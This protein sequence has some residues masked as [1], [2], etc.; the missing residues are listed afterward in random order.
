MQRRERDTYPPQT[1]HSAG[2]EMK[3]DDKAIAYY[4]ETVT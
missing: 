2:Q 1:P 3:H 4:K